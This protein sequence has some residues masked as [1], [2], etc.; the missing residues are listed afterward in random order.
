MY[1][2]GIMPIFQSHYHSNKFL[3]I[4]DLGGPFLV[5]TFHGGS[6]GAPCPFRNPRVFIQ[7]MPDSVHIGMNVLLPGVGVPWCPMVQSIKRMRE[8][9]MLWHHIK[10]ISKAYLESTNLLISR[11]HTIDQT[12]SMGNFAD[13]Q[14][15]FSTSKHPIFSPIRLLCHPYH[16][17]MVYLPA[18]TIKINHSCR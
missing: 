6:C 5:L 17:C 9:Q 2:Y 15:M 8:E 16:P 1:M 14:K 18:F 7:V 12:F 11:D 3:V 13:R 4:F 10:I